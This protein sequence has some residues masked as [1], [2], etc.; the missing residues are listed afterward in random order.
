MM[1]GSGKNKGFSKRDPAKNQGET[2]TW[3]TK[4]IKKRSSRFKDTQLTQT[5]HLQFQESGHG[6]E[7]V[8]GL[9]EGWMRVSSIVDSGAAES[10]APHTTCPVIPLIES[11]RSRA[12]QECRTAD[13]ERLRNGG[14]RH[15]QASTDEGCLLE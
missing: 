3:C 1:K 10:V 12:S 15:I 8:H 11:L 5:T 2:E 7:M 6:E 4:I 13:G 14:Q 9:D